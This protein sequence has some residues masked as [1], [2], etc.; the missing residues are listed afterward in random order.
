[1]FCSVPLIA[2]VHTDIWLEGG[3]FDDTESGT[4]QDHLFCRVRVNNR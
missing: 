2:G 1:M 3:G 4:T